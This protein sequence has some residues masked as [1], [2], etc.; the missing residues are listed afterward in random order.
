[1][2]LLCDTL[3]VLVLLCALC[4]GEL[5]RFIEHS[6]GIDVLKAQEQEQDRWYDLTG[7]AF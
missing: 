2:T 5:L 7:H 4:S 6:R 1:M 3:T